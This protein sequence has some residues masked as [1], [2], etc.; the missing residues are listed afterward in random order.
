MD[1]P[2]TPK[3]GIN[4]RIT[5]FFLNNNRTTILFFILL[6]IVGIF[7][8]FSLKTT[9]FP[10]PE[11]KLI[12]I[13]TPYPGA[14]AK[15]VEQ[16]VTL[17]IEKIVKGLKGVD[18][19]NSTSANSFSSVSVSLSDDSNLSSLKSELDSEISSIAFPENVVKPKIVDPDFSDPDFLYFVKGLNIQETYNQ[20]QILKSEINNL[21]ETSSVEEDV[22]L[23]RY[24]E[25]TF[26]TKKTQEG[27]LNI[28]DVQDKIKN[29][30]QSIPVASDQKIDSENK[31]IV[32]ANNSSSL[33]DLEGQRFIDNVGNFL[34]LKDFATIKIEYKYTDSENFS[35]GLTINDEKYFDIG[36]VL[37]IQVND[38]VDTGV[39][40]KKLAEKIKNINSIKLVEDGLLDNVR[41]VNFIIPLRSINTSNQEQVDEVVGGLI[42]SPLQVDNP[43]LSQAGWLL[44]GIQLVF[45][46][47]LAFVSWRAA[48]IATTAIPLSLIFST[49]YLWATGN[50]LNTL[51]LFSLVLV[52]GLVVDPALV[53]L[54]SI[55]RK[56]DSGYKG[57]IA[58]LEA[59]KDV[60]GGL[61]LATLT[62]IIVF[63]PFGL[64]SGFLGE[65]FSYIP[66]TIIPAVVG[67][68]IVPLIFL[69]W[70]GGG[71]LRKNKGVKI[72]ATEIDNMWSV[73]KILRRFNFW[74]L[75]GNRFL[76][77][78]IIS[79]FLVASVGISG[80]Y[81]STGQVKSVQFSGTSD[82][83]Y[84]ILGGEFFAKTP[85]SEREKLGNSVLQ[86]VANNSDVLSVFKQGSGFNYYVSLTKQQDREL[87]A[88]EISE[89]IEKELIQYQDEFF[90]LTL[91]PESTGPP[92]AG[93]QIALGVSN[94]DDR[95]LRTSGVAVGQ[96][97][98][99]LCSRDNE[100]I[101]VDNCGDRVKD[102]KLISKIDNGFDGKESSVINIGI[103]ENDFNKLNLSSSGIPANLLVAGFISPYFES[104][105]NNSDQIKIE[106][107]EYKLK[108]SSNDLKNNVTLNEIK[109]IQIGFP[110]PTENSLEP[111]STKRIVDIANIKEELPQ[112]KINR[113]NGQTINVVQAKLVD[114]YTDESTAGMAIKAVEDFYR[115]NDYAETKKLGLKKESIS[116][117]SEGSSEGFAKSFRELI[118]SLL[119]AIILT[120]IVLAIFFG[121]LSMPF[122]VLYT[123][124][125]TFIGIFPAIA[126]L[127]I[128][129]FGF[130]EIIGLIILVGIVENAAIF[131]V[132]AARQYINDGMR[133][134][135][136]IAL[137]SAI[138][139]RP[140][141]LTTLTAT[142]SLAPLA[143]FS[144]FYRSLS[145][146]II[147]GLLTSGLISLVTTPILFVFFNSLSRK[148]HSLKGVHKVLVFPLLPIYILI[149]FFK[150]FKRKENMVKIESRINIYDK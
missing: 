44:G 68:Y 145:I 59:I 121:S 82:S 22:K 19:Y 2:H 27:G 120:Y 122:V 24:L 67:S 141:I 29:F 106:D 136:A 53:I 108:F 66:L 46:V 130:L 43:I 18:T 83:D 127:G 100:I 11:I 9:G 4:Y 147:F 69:A 101:I 61:F 110:S 73:A 14:S 51:V 86:L 75:S 138:R 48:V 39:F 7:S 90:D 116:A 84:L 31:S 146:V 150:R 71:F 70:F 55:Q 125:L 57:K 91:S 135:E 80:Y 111:S 34:E 30:D 56:V 52:I 137:A 58:A 112:S 32:I 98:D 99:K 119:L 129:Q 117:Y 87:T 35:T 41:D 143:I 6:L 25:I 140:I 28:D 148:Y 118:I 126:K 102:V 109:N 134:K 93:W 20:L 10:S 115:N 78:L 15:T 49:I 107:Q 5:E 60:G 36:S 128:G 144:E 74:L 40:E 79:V 50:D 64:I 63:A 123:I 1:K 65:I 33:S 149:S 42:G 114:G 113:V 124:P 85:S 133:E 104:Q 95:T 97:I 37:K 142:A 92:A 12:L 89:N 54:E 88:F 81:F 96:T 76:Q 47:M 3:K 105:T 45:I 62:N 132:D 17:P 94:E 21:P 131:L 26:D 72:G 16:D 103:R 38:G 77:F 13:N 139:M 8:I 23:E